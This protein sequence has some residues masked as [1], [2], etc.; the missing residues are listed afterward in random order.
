MRVSPFLPLFM[1]DS[2]F[3]DFLDDVCLERPK[4]LH[5]Y[6][7]TSPSPHPLPTP[8]PH[9]WGNDRGVGWRSSRIGERKERVRREDPKRSEGMRRTQ[10]SFTG[11]NN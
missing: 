1:F 6:L 11:P 8:L 4:D 3:L 5:S 10:F 9:L 7:T 2:F